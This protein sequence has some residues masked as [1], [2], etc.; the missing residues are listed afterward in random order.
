MHRLLNRERNL[1]YLRQGKQP[2]KYVT[3]I[4]TLS[5]LIGCSPLKWRLESNLKKIDY[6]NG[7]NRTEATT[8][9]EYY[10]LNNISRFGLA[11]PIDGGDVWIFKLVKSSTGELADAPPV[12]VR[13]NAWSFQSAVSFDKSKY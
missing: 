11:D 9:A 13:K 10:R 2:M 1:Y 5:I 3:I 7:I 8:I 6:S 4:I 12:M